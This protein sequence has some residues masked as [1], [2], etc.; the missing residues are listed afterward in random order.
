MFILFWF[1]IG[2]MLLTSFALASSVWGVSRFTT[3]LIALTSLAVLVALPVLLLKD[4]VQPK[5]LWSEGNAFS[6]RLE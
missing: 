5:S 4:R 6:D 1:D 3:D 2:L